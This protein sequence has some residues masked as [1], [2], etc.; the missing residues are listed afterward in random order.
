MIGFKC[1]SIFINLAFKKWLK[2]LLGEETYQI[3]DQA[4][5]VSN[6]SSHDA[7][8]ERMRVLMKNFD[9]HKRKFAKGHRSIKIDLP[10]PFENLNKENI[11]VGGQIT[12]T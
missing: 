5:V 12:I 8:G 11:V 9:V 1:G 4:Q 10:E 6:I 7:E 3:L 2:C